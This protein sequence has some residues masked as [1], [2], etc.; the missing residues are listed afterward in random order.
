M[1]RAGR[2]WH[3]ESIHVPYVNKYNEEHEILQKLAS[4]WLDVGDSQGL[5]MFYCPSC[6]YPILQYKG[7]VVTILPG[8]SPSQLPL[9]VQCKGRNCGKKYVFNLMLRSV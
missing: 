6:R 8:D 5:Q 3:S 7:D 9:V 1:T 4:V 2:A